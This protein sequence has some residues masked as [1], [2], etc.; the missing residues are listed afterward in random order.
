MKIPAT[1]RAA[2]LTAYPQKDS[3]LKDCLSVVPDHP[4]PSQAVKDEIIVKVMAVSVNPGD[5]FV[6]RGWLTMMHDALPLVMGIDFA[7]T[8]HKAR[9]RLM[10]VWSDLSDLWSL[11]LTG[12]VVA[13]GEKCTRL[14]VGDRVYGAANFPKMGSFAEYFKCTEEQAAKM[15]N[16]LSF[17]EAATIPTVGLVSQLAVTG[18][19]I[20]AANKVVV[21][22]GSGGVGSFTTQLVKALSNAHVAVTCS[23]RNANFVQSI[24][25]DEVSVLLACFIM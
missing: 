4:A 24:G 18:A 12:I 19:K 16:N 20:Q 5:V 21:L 8:V 10:L 25:A 3:E 15:P 17:Q 13:T 22:G 14:N 23:Q 1:M 11:V 2:V 7:G 9:P 6:A